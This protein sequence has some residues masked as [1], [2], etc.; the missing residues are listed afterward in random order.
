MDQRSDLNEQRPDEIRHQIEETRCSLTEKLETLEHEVKQT[1][2]GATDTVVGTVH[3]VEGTVETV[4][5]TFDLRYHVRR[6]PWLMFGGSIATGF[7][8]GTLLP[9]EISIPKAMSRSSISN[10]RATRST[11]SWTSETRESAPRF[12][13]NALAPA[14]DQPSAGCGKIGLPDAS[15]TVAVNCCWL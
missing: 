14:A 1:V 12:E 13:V 8:A 11:E 3:S 6:H 5:R 10:G 4:K 15:S 2:K 9:H 7:V